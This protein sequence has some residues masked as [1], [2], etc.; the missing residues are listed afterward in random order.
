MQIQSLLTKLFEQDESIKSSKQELCRLNGENLNL[1]S[2]IVDLEAKVFSMEKSHGNKSHNPHAILN[3][4]KPLNPSINDNDIITT[5]P[6]TS[7]VVPSADKSNSEI[8]VSTY[9]NLTSQPQSQQINNRYDRPPKNF[10][11]C[12]FLSRRGW[13]RK[14]D[15]CDFQH[16][17]PSRD[18]HNHNVPRPFLQLQPQSQQTN[19]RYDRPPKNSTSCPFLSRRGWCRKG[20]QC[21][22]QHLKSS[23][24]THKHNVPCPFLQ[25]RGFCLKDN[26]Y[27]YR[28]SHALV[29]TRRSA[30]RT[31]TSSHLPP[32]SFLSRVQVPRPWRPQ[33][34][35]TPLMEIPLPSS[36]FPR[37]PSHPYF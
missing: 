26:R 34:H 24:D 31:T 27:D 6:A 25:N 19:N 7:L 2:R 8:S 5:S 30:L 15:Q 33:S 17:K 14:G 32:A 36:S 9:G 13:C 22:F 28:I 10:T 12:P 16:L 20:D 11:P 3:K 23:C 1:K 4:D 37:L 35:P 18:T 21:D 29:P